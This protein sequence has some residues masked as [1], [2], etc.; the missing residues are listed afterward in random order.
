MRIR[1]L[2]TSAL[3]KINLSTIARPL[4]FAAVGGLGTYLFIFPKNNKEN[5]EKLNLSLE[6]AR[7]EGAKLQINNKANYIKYQAAYKKNKIFLKRQECY[8][9][10]INQYKEFKQAGWVPFKLYLKE[11]ICEEKNPLTDNT[12][13]SQ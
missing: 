13:S 8:D 9:N 4:A 5:I 10:E 11:K 2:I 7:Q 6:K 1:N 3:S 12:E